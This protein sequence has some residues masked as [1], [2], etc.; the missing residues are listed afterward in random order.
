[1]LMRAPAYVRLGENMSG[2]IR[3]GDSGTGCITYLLGGVVEV[4]VHQ[5][6]PRDP[7]SAVLTARCQQGRSALS[8]GSA[9]SSKG[10]RRRAAGVRAPPRA[11]RTLRLSSRGSPAAGKARGVQFGRGLAGGGAARP[12]SSLCYISRV[13]S[14][15]ECVVW[16]RAYRRRGCAPWSLLLFPNLGSS[17]LAGF[18]L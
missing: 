7:S 1:V 16:P 13:S 14:D 6:R 3:T 12:C 15:V 4:A 5:A 11:C 8:W 18:D 17:F 10:G 2:S 9:A